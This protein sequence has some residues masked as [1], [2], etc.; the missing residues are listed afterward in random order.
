MLMLIKTEE[1]V[2]LLTL[3]DMFREMVDALDVIET[4]A[5]D[6]DEAE[7]DGKALGVII[8]IQNAA[9]PLLNDFVIQWG[10]VLP[11]NRE[12]RLRVRKFTQEVPIAAV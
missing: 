9:K 12:T 3:G 11:D 2:R 1:L 6:P 10:A 5:V 8:D 4:E 7:T